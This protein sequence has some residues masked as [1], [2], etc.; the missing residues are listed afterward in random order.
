LACHH[1][2]Y[3]GHDSI[4]ILE[5]MLMNEPMINMDDLYLFNHGR[6]FEAYRVLGAHLMEW[7]GQRGCRFAVW[8]PHAVE[9]HVIGTFNDWAGTGLRMEQAGSTG[10][11]LVFA[12]GVSEGDAY[13]FKIKT[14]EG[15]TIEK[16]D[17]F[18][19]R[20]DLRPGTN[21]IVTDLTDIAWTDADWQARKQNR[22]STSRPINIYEVHLGSWKV[23]G[24]EWFYTYDELAVELVD[25]AA[26]MGYTHLELL[27][28][29]EHPLDASWGYQA[30]GYYAA[31]ARY[32]TPQG[33]MRL[34]NRAHERG[35]GVILDW[36][37]GHYCR[38]DYGLRWFD[39]EPLFEPPDERMAD[40]PLWGAS[41]FDFARTEVRSFL[42]SNAVFWLQKYHVD[43]LRVDA[44]ASMLDRNF[45]KPQS[46]W[47]WSHNGDKR[48]E[49]AVQFLRQLNE[50]VSSYIPGALMIA[51]DSSD[52]P[53]V[54][55]STANGGLGFTYKW[56]MGWMN[57]MLTFMQL[58]P[59]SRQASHHLL[60]F[61]MM[62][63]YSERYVLP[64]SHDESVHGKKSLLN[65][66]P[67]D[68]QAKFANLRLFMAFMMGHP[69]G[70]LLFMG[71]EWAQFD[72]WYDRRG[73]DWGL[74]SYDMHRSFFHF[75]KEMNLLYRQEPALWERDGDPSGFAW[76]DVDN[77]AQSV[78]SFTRS[79]GSGKRT[80]VFVCNFQDQSYEAFRVGFPKPVTYTELISTQDQAFG[81]WQPSVHRQYKAETIA[82]HGRS[83]SAELV[84]PAL[85]TVILIQED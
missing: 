70:K 34:V 33:L 20:S 46:M 74:L 29:A 49:E 16:A 50:V 76:I 65:K 38:D 77:A 80:L 81:G 44:V 37:P 64:L 28:L 85:S 5:A 21:S 39:G 62:Y 3:Q 15:R 72:E 4:F 61:S 52:F 23:H 83:Y 54:T 2:Q 12:A 45:D 14:K 51:E 78:V 59:R 7:Y 66:M 24:E 9:V 22:P 63:A 47:T 18:A 60:T 6:L 75:M 58:E 32:G 25:Y 42:I 71:G 19:F 26:E 13:K 67:G 30:T 31:T 35:I 27:P 84:L 1:E 17:P 82:W 56:N 73:L 43:G 40:K 8:A 48:N 55:A 53:Q 69:G 11:W 10:V 79:S 41:A 68:Y 36:V 57:D